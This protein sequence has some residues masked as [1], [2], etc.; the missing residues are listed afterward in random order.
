MFTYHL[1]KRLSDRHMIHSWMLQRS[2][3]YPSGM[4]WLQGFGA[5]PVSWRSPGSA[6][7]PALEIFNFSGSASSGDISIFREALAPKFLSKLLTLVLARAPRPCLAA[8]IFW[9]FSWNF[10]SSSHITYMGSYCN[11]C[12]VPEF[13]YN[14]FCYRSCN[15]SSGIQTALIRPKL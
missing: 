1:V 4:S 8:L 5:G 3:V 15:L 7:A 9:H 12:N 11:S 6:R 13:F 14:K 10:E 2:I